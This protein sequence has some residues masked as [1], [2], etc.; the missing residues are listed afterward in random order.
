[1]ERLLLTLWSSLAVIVLVCT[2]ALAIEEITYKDYD[3]QKLNDLQKKL[4]NQSSNIDERINKLEEETAPQAVLNELKQ[5]KE[6]IDAAVNKVNRA[7]EDSWEKVRDVVEHD[8]NNTQE[9]LYEAGA[10]AENYDIDGSDD[11]WDVK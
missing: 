6:E 4:E 10:F 9:Q 2:P 7:N 3:F 1:M 11:W 8:I 5:A